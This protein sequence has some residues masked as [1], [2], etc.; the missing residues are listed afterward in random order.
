MFVCTANVCRSPLMAYTFM[1]AVDASGFA[2]DWTV[3]SAGA[4]VG[5]QSELCEVGAALISDEVAGGEFA[6]SHVAT[7]LSASDLESSDLIIT[8][9][10]TERAVI[11]RLLPELRSRTFTLK[12]ALALGADPIT[13]DEL[14][15]AAQSDEKR[16]ALGVYAAALNDRRGRIT[17][18]T[19]SGLRM[20][21]LRKADPRDIP[22]VHHDG[23]R[24]HAATLRS[25]RAAVKELH[26]DIEPSF[27]TERRAS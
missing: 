18:P 14:E 19:R 4:D 24:V 13:S 15:T 16:S 26:R 10:R 20:P 2:D 9:S 12:E 6:T 8:A 27:D 22:D 7:A 21:W 23:A 25:L 1:Q 17:W 3:T 5:G 11:A